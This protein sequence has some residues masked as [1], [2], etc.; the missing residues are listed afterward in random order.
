MAYCGIPGDSKIILGKTRAILLCV[1]VVTITGACG[2]V[3]G[4]GRASTRQSFPKIN[5]TTVKFAFSDSDLTTFRIKL[6]Q[7]ISSSITIS[8]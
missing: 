1:P 4:F 6:P 8:I 7:N 2:S 3:I 5:T